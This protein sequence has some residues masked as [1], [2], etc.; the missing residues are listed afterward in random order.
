VN[1]IH[2]IDTVEENVPC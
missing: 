2:I 1:L